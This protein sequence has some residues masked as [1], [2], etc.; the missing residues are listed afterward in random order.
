[1]ASQWKKEAWN[2]TNETKRWF[3]FFSD[4]QS[5]AGAKTGTALAAAQGPNEWTAG[6]SRSKS[7]PDDIW[8]T[9]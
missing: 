1:M 5:N 3:A 7:G 9:Q 4:A 2:N 8:S 6:H